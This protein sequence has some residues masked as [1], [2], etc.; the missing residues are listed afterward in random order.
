ME[1]N[2]FSTEH[3]WINW[4]EPTS[5]GRRS[6][7]RQTC[8]QVTEISKFKMKSRFDFIRVYS[9]VFRFNLFC[10]QVR[11]IWSRL[12]KC[13]MNTE[14]IKENSW[15]A[16]WLYIET[17]FEEVVS[18]DC[19][20]IFESFSRCTTE[21]LLKFYKY[22]IFKMVEAKFIWAQ[23]K[24]FGTDDLRGV[25]KLVSSGPIKFSRN[26]KYWYSQAQNC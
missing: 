17:W 21:P 6:F 25:F 10:C 9:D 4:L 12:T 1:I 20:E 22:S 5:L 26:L 11:S 3:H 7:Q 24:C 14:K 16:W 15:N 19:Q 2:H 23:L 18:R 8:V 13:M